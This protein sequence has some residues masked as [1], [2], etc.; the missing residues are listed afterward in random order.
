MIKLRYSL[1]ISLLLISSL[2]FAQKNN[3]TSFIMDKVRNEPDYI[4][5][6]NKYKF[7]AAEARIERSM[8]WF[9]INL[10]YKNYTNEIGRLEKKLSS[11]EDS[12]IQ[13]DD[14]RW[15][16]EL[17]RRFFDKDFS[18]S[19]NKLESKIKQIRYRYELILQQYIQIDEVLDDMI[20][21]EEAISKVK[22]LNAKLD[23]KVEENLIFEDL[24]MQQIIEP[25]ELIENLESIEDLEDELS[26]WK[27][28]TEQ[29]LLTNDHSHQEFISMFTGYLVTTMEEADTT[30]F[31]ETMKYYDGQRK[32]DILKAANMINRAEYSYLLPELQLSFSMNNR[33]TDQSWEIVK[34]SDDYKTS[35]R[36]I[37]EN[38]LEGEAEISLPFDL[39]SNI[40]GKKLLLK[41]FQRELSFREEMLDLDFNSFKTKVLN[42][43]YKYKIRY[44]R[45]KRLEEL[46]AKQWEVLKKSSANDAIDKKKNNK[47]IKAEA[48]YQKAKLNCYITRLKLYKNIYLINYFGEINEINP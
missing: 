30:K 5:S 8:N 29:Y 3:L 24:Y 48:R 14:E 15:K 32:K 6:F 2:S 36:E 35:K 19:S 27:L 18:T 17:T 42:S 45:K 16:L 47:L 39:Y 33:K 28:V 26:E 13:E 22:H 43:Y 20:K 41:S 11:T 34:D 44:Q 7:E 25:A 12:T 38:F 31:I 10:S 46:Y 4:S 1:L 9:D 21:Y 37:E 23:L 40:S